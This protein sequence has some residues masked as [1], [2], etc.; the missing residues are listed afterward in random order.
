MLL[1]TYCS[2]IKYMNIIHFDKMCPILVLPTSSIPTLPLILSD[3]MYFFKL[4]ES[5]YYS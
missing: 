3:L 2:K 1:K 5:L 4:T